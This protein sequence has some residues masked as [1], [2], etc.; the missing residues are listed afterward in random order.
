MAT[1]IGLYLNGIDGEMTATGL[2]GCIEVQSFSWGGSN[3]CSP[4][5]GGGWSGGK[6]MANA[7]NVMG[8]VDKSMGPLLNYSRSGK[9]VDKG[10]LRIRKQ[11]GDGGQQVFLVYK[12]GDVFV[13]SYQMSGSTGGTDYPSVAVSLAFGTL[14]LEY[15]LQDASQNLTVQTSFS[16][17]VR[18]VAAAT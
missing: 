7:V 6:F 12:M 14:T 16:I 5:T 18:K 9:T 3:S 1:D 4:Q 15:S 11:T 8:H 10:E 13:E 2:E 17:D